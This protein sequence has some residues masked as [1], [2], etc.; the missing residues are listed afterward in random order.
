MSFLSYHETYYREKIT[1]YEQKALT[2]T[3]LYEA[4]QLL[5]LLD[6]FADEGY[7]E[8]NE[9]LERRFQGVTRLRKL[10]LSNGATSFA[11]PVRAA[12]A[13]SY[14][15]REYALSALIEEALSGAASAE[16]SASSPF[17]QEIR[18][19]C[20]WLGRERDT[21]YIF[22]LRDC[23]LP[24]L[25]GAVRGGCGALYPWLI[26]RSFLKDFTAAENSDDRL[27]LAVYDALEA[28][29]SDYET[30]LLFCKKRMRAF[31]SGQPR[32]L[33]V[34][35]G[36]LRAIQQP[37]ILV[38]ESGCCGTMPLL[39]AAADDRVEIRMFTAAPYLYGIY[40][41]RLF[42]RAYEKMRSFETLYSQD[43]YL[44]Y[45]DFRNG[46]FYVRKAQDSRIVKEAF[47]EINTVCF[48]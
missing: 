44:R 42:C 20:A 39:L 31:L 10:L 21:A 1:A 46:T 3:E 17:L 37:R 5:K 7:M 22:L 15:E 35:E 48:G 29:I 2:G 4:K 23:F 30:F 27:R 25:Y 43:L 47:A 36:L 28:G 26:G 18:A 34:L 8:L 45:S 41:D 12:A 14:S 40:G 11:L 13:C 16:R 33:H 38:V 9:H 24:Y 32:L 19:Y 6:D